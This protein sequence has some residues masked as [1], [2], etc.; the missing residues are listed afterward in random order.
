VAVAVILTALILV[1]LPA[2]LVIVTVAPS[3]KVNNKA[4]NHRLQILYL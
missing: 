1:E 3:R 4:M 2:G